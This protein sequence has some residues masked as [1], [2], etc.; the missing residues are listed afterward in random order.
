MLRDRGDYRPPEAGAQA[1]LEIAGTTGL[2]RRER[3][4]ESSRPV[5][6]GRGGATIFIGAASRRL[7]A[8]R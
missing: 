4:R 8:S 6:H 3:R 2:R 7:G 1:R 5:D